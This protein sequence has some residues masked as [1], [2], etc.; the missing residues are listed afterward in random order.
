MPDLA[1]GVSKLLEACDDDVAARVL[2]GAAFLEDKP[3]N[4]AEDPHAGCEGDEHGETPVVVGFAVVDVQAEHD[5]D[6]DG[7]DDDFEYGLHVEG[8]IGELVALHHIGE[9][10]LGT[11]DAAFSEFFGFDAQLFCVSC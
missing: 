4:G 7:E 6:D 3:G 8:G 9:V 11:G 2:A 1:H 5:P 10:V